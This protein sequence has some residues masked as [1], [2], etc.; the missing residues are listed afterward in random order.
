MLSANVGSNAISATVPFLLSP[1]TSCISCALYSRL[2][3]G[4]ASRSG[5]STSRAGMQLQS[6]SQFQVMS[7]GSY[8][9]TA[10]CMR[11]VR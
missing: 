10:Y 8:I 6:G 4:M 9:G 7:C 3:D 1:S 11:Q 2:D 5:C